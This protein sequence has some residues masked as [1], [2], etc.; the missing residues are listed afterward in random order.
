VVQDRGALKIN[1]IDSMT[2]FA[3]GQ[4]LT[5]EIKAGRAFNF[6]DFLQANTYNTVVLPS[7]L[8]KRS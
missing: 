6:G 1:A 7:A 3:N 4:L 2:Q 5:D 8:A